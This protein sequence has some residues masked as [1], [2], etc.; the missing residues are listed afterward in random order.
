MTTELK[1]LSERILAKVDSKKLKNIKSMTGLVETSCK[2]VEESYIRLNKHSK[3][4][5]KR[6]TAVF[7]LQPLLEKMKAQDLV[8]QTVADRLEEEI[9]SSHLAEIVDDIISSWNERLGEVHYYCT[10]FDAFIKAIK[11]E[12]RRG[13]FVEI[14]L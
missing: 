4:S 9:S 12:K 2:I 3:G 7:L 14:E 13:P 1:N 8:T 6:D 5:D 11:R 10:I